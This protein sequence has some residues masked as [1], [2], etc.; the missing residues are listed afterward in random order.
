MESLRELYKVGVGP[1]SSHTMGPQRAAKQIL[2][3]YPEAKRFHVDLH[4]SLALTGKGHLTD[5]I[6]EKTFEPIPVTFSFKSEELPFHPNGMII[7]VFDDKDEEIRAIE[8]YSI[9]GGSICF[10]GEMAQSPKQ[11]YKQHN[12]EE[13]LQYVDKHA[14]SLYDYILEYEGEDFVY[15]LYEILNAMFESVENGLRKE[16]TIH[17]KLKLKRVAKSIFQQAQNTRRESD[18][19]RLFIS[20]YAYA[21]AE[22]NADGGKIV[23]APTC[24]ASGIMPAVLYYCYK[25]LNIEKKDLIKALAVGGLFGNVVKHNATISGADGGCQAEV[26]TACAMAAATMAWIYELNNSLI[27]YA[28]EM[29]LEHNLGLTCDPVGGYVQIPCIERNGYGSLRALDAAMLAKQLGYLRKNKVS[30]DTIVRVMKETGK[31]LSSAY[32]E[33]SLGGLAKEFGL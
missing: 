26:G 4:G 16:G 31:D 11:V 18:R 30:F 33:T 20:S 14:I 27:E 13:I 17:G 1:S 3:M 7:H 25:Q 24:G 19:E 22:E 21:V 5:Y 8:V 9:G 12:M 23:T 15:Y 10:K 6:I 28:A 2:E 32:K 29:G